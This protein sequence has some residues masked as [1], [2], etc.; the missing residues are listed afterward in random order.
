[1][2]ILLIS[3][4]RCKENL[5]PYPLGIAFVATAVKE[6]GHEVSCLDLMFSD[7]P[8]LEVTQRIDS[9]QPE[10]IGLS[11]RNI[12]NQDMHENVF[13]MPQVKEISDAIK[14]HTDAPII[15]GGAGFSLFPR[16]ILDYLGLEMGIVGEGERSFVQLLQDLGA[17]DDIR[18]IPGL[19]MRTDG[20]T[21][22]NQPDL[23][24]DLSELLPPD[25][26]LFD[27]A[28]YNWIKGKGPPSMPNLQARRGCHMKCI[29]C[30]NPSIEGRR[31]RV[32]KA[33]LVA[34][35][36][37]SLQRHYGCANAVFADSLF[38]YPADYTLDLCREIAARQLSIKWHGNLNPL[39]CQ[40]EL[41]EALRNSGCVSLSI[42]NES[43]SDNILASLKKGFSKQDVI[44][45]ITE[46]KRLGF[47]LNCFLL[48]GGPGENDDTVTESV[49]LLDRLEVDAVRVS[50]GLRIFP[51]C[52]MYDIA[53]REGF[54]SRNQN[55]LYPAFYV[56][57]QTESWLYEYMRKVCEER[58]G[59]FI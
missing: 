46:A 53:L 41:L 20:T 25:R 52:E 59:W 6:A 31:V 27:V 24:P 56:S 54:I 55:L 10:C 44:R 36:L 34:A 47:Y 43:G 21:L 30:S 39:Y 13:Y 40:P 23:L 35:E 14:S 9:F 37:A 51:D 38:S 2:K 57:H 3:E 28:P 19:A 32:R 5:I 49:E 8:V 29:Y 15:L 12:D 22:I 33:E 45:S 50:V 58:E 18:N 16:E 26:D 11:V 48:L 42:G 7:D 17:G 1:M 4:N